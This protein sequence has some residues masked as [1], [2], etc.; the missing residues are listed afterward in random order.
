MGFLSD[1]PGTLLEQYRVGGPVM[2]LIS[3]CSVLALT[4]ILYKTYVFRRARTD[5]GTLI[6]GVRRAVAA[7]KIK[8]ATEL[9]ERHR[10][11][12]AVALKIGLL[13]SEL[14]EDKI[15]RHMDSAEIHEL[16]HLERYLNVLATISNIAPLI[17]FF[18]TVIGMI[19]SFK[20]L[21]IRGMD[22]PELV[23]EGISVALVTTAYGLLVAFITQPFYNYFVGR[24]Q[25]LE[26]QIEIARITLLDALGR[27]RTP[28]EPAHR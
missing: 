26:S 25:A 10:G 4:G 23:A 28:V 3:V 14:P 20:I 1:L 5:T 11:P 12:V 18:G 7:G 24:V 16:S 19:M 2:H 21:A 13:N 9:C 15:E 8:Q 22:H 27:S 17:G 6:D